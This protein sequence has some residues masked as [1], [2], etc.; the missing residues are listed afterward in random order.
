MKL[1]GFVVSRENVCS[2]IGLIYW[3]DTDFTTRV[4]R[5]FN[6]GKYAD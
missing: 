4:L 2:E 3:I 5:E 6:F 1:S